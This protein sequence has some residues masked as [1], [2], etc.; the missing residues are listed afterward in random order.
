MYSKS[1]PWL[2][3]WFFEFVQVNEFFFQHVVERF[4]TGVIVAIALTAHV[5][6]HAVLS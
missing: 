4:N 5:A 6:R 2:L 3:S 1:S